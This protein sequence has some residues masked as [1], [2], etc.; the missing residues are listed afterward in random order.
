MYG[1]YQNQDLQCQQT[2]Y[3]KGLLVDYKNVKFKNIAVVSNADGYDYVIK[4]I[5]P[6]YSNY[7]IFKV[8]SEN[9]IDE[10]NMILQQSLEN[11]AS[12]NVIIF[13]I[14]NYSKIKISI[15]CT[16]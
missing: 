1:N 15:C 13:G 5:L 12:A 4:N 2:V 3:D 14:Q 6:L 10:R 9:T 16:Q 8:D 7:W 11:D